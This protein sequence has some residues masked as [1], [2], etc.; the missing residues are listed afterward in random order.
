M[1]NATNLLNMIAAK[2]GTTDKN[3]VIS[4]AIAMLVKSG[5]DVAAAFD[6]IVGEGAYKKMAGEVWTELRAKA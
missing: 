5:V 2:I 3:L 4:T 6:M 1:T